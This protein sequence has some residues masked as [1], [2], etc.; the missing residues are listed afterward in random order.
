MGD[1]IEEIKQG[2]ING[3]LGLDQIDWSRAGKIWECWKCEPCCGSPVNAKDAIYCMFMWW[4]CGFCTHSKMYASSMNHPCSCVPHVLFT[5]FCPF[6]ANCFMRYN[7]RKKNGVAGNLI[8]DCMCTYF[9]GC[10]SSLQMLRASQVADWDL[11][12]FNFLPAA[13]DIKVIV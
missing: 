2:G 1:K 12:P 7:L 10:C 3:C 13:P 9:C 6:F 8:G 11:L 4:C 5:F